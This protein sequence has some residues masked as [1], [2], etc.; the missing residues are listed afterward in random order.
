MKYFLFYVGDKQLLIKIDQNDNSDHT[1][2]IIS[3]LQVSLSV[4]SVTVD[5]YID[6]YTPTYKNPDF[7]N[8]ENNKTYSKITKS[9]IY[10]AFKVFDIVLLE[11][12]I[13]NSQHIIIGVAIL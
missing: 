3:A 5:L 1:N 9:E 7:L 4:I 2:D 10:N 11:L 8:P 13:V 12:L 6:C